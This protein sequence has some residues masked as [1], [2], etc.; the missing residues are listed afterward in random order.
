MS[1]LRKCASYLYA[2]ALRE[3]IIQQS[4]AYAEI[5]DKNETLGKKIRIAE[6]QHTPLIVVLG[7]KE[8]ESKILAIRDRTTREQYTLSE[9][10]FIA[11]LYTKISEVR[12]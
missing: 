1:H 2:Q 6:K 8:V 10:E 12:I 4:G 5:L 7:E 11:M 3:K 9:E